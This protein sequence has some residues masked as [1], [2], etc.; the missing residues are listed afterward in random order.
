[1]ETLTLNITTSDCK[2]TR[3]SFLATYFATDLAAVETSFAGD[4]VAG[5]S[6]HAGQ[7]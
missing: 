3:P 5:G 1:M 2:G 7:G 4:S 6:K